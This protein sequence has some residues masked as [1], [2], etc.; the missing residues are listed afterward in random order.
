MTMQAIVNMSAPI[1]E[2]EI[3]DS[4]ILEAVVDGSFGVNIMTYKTKQKLGLTNLESTP[5]VI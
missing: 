2:V 4:I 3:D 1:I 5:F